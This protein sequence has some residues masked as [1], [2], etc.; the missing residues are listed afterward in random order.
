M[1]TTP[2]NTT[3]IVGALPVSEPTIS[4]KLETNNY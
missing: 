4:R 2:F 3:V 1:K